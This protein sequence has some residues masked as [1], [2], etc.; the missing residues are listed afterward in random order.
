MTLLETIVSNL[1]V[2]SSIQFPSGRISITESGHGPLNRRVLT[3]KTEEADERPTDETK[4][5]R[6]RDPT[7]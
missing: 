6:G 4:T 1:F 5:T 7:P 3:A 2:S